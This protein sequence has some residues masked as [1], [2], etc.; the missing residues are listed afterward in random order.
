MGVLNAYPFK[1][2]QFFQVIE[3][4]P[5]W[6]HSI[7]G[8]LKFRKET[9]YPIFFQPV[10]K[11]T[12]YRNLFFLFKLH[13]RNSTSPKIDVFVMKCTNTIHSTQILPDHLS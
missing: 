5:I 10:Q 7:Q 9:Y 1:Q 3:V 2:T 13:H 4:K 8:F 12:V 11:E 6:I